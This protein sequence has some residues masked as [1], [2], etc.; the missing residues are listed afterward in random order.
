ML[1]TV[2]PGAQGQL[3][4]ANSSL[5]G[6]GGLTSF[7]QLQMIQVNDDVSID[8]GNGDSITIQKFLVGTMAEG[9]FNI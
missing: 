2:E 4:G 9:M 3:Q 7:D 6:I 1:V 8:L 5:T